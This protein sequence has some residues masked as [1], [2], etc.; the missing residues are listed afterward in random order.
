M[1]SCMCRCGNR[2]L[3]SLL[4]I[5][6]FSFV[7]GPFGF[8]PRI[9]PF[10]FKKKKLV[11]KDIPFS[12]GIFLCT[13]PQTLFPSFVNQ[14]NFFWIIF[15]FK[16]W[17]S[18]RTLKNWPLRK[19]TRNWRKFEPKLLSSSRTST[20]A[21]LSSKTQP[22]ISDFRTHFKFSSNSSFNNGR[23]FK[24]TPIKLKFEI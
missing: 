19:W 6:S 3:D 24:P 13:N 21:I 20:Q 16:R 14:T 22:K 7:V 5:S 1:A 12:L 2:C 10:L 11:T 17:T 18:T 23:T 4:E 9:Y 15:F 8:S